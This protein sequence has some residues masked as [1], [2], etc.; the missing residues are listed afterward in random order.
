[1]HI[2][3]C[4]CMHVL[5]NEMINYECEIWIMSTMVT[6]MF[7]G[8]S[9][10]HTINPCIYYGAWSGSLLSFLPLSLTTYLLGK[11]TENFCHK[12]PNNKY[13]RICVPC[14]LCCNY[15]TLL[16]QLENSHRQYRSKWAWLLTYKT[17]FS[18]T[19]C[20]RNFAHKLIYW[21]FF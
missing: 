8:N 14:G 12:K 15:L 17:L 9:L 19:G 18:T 20:R 2:C 3:L 4:I 10:F 11:E 13:Y 21:Y 16:L 1:M 7:K 5:S 6:R